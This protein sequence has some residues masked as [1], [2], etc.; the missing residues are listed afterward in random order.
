MENL[1]TIII[2]VAMIFLTLTFILLI[3]ELYNYFLDKG[4]K[5][6]RRKFHWKWTVGFFIIYIILIII[7]VIIINQ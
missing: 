5:Q 1:G 7:G 2:S 6:V 3:I 4:G